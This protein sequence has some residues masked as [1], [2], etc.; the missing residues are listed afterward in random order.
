MKRYD[1]LSASLAKQKAL[2]IKQFPNFQDKAYEDTCIGITYDDKFGRLAEYIKYPEDYGTFR[3]LAKSISGFTEAR[4]LEIEAGAKLQ[5]TE[6][7]ILK[8]HIADNDDPDSWLGVHGWE[9]RFEDG[10]VFLV[11][12][13]ESQGQGGISLSYARAFENKRAANAWFETFEIFSY[14]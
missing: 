13:G 11:F 12:W 7:K 6:K 3:I 2:V 8:Q 10:N 14:M 1:F 5:K 4:R 9:M